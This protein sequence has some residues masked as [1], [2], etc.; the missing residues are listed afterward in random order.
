MTVLSF[1]EPYLFFP[2]H[3]RPLSLLK[4]TTLNQGPKILSLRPVTLTSM[5]PYFPWRLEAAYV[6]VQR[7]IDFAVSGRN[8]SRCV[9]WAFTKNRVAPPAL[10]FCFALFLCCFWNRERERVESKTSSVLFVQVTADVYH[11]WPFTAGCQ[12]SE[13]WSQ[14][15][16]LSLLI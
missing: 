5:E 10:H 8:A 16:D 3:I 4:H 13:G 7:F 11:V 2:Q 6:S 14:L 9:A 12:L 1:I 15:S